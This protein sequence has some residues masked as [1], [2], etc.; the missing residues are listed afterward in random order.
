LGD[1]DFSISEIPIAFNY[2]AMAENTYN[3]V[4]ELPKID[5]KLEERLDEI[6][7]L[8]ETVNLIRTELETAKAELNEERKSH[9]HDFLKSV[10]LGILCTILGAILGILLPIIVK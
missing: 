5:L 4:N 2:N 10:V 1:T 7:K 8:N 9:K 6:K 3:L